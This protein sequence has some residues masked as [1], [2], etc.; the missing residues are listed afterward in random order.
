M[1]HFNYQSILRSIHLSKTPILIGGCPR[2]GTSLLLSILGAHS[3]IFAYPDETQIFWKKW[4][5]KSLQYHRI[6]HLNAFYQRLIQEDIPYGKTHWCEK[7]PLN[8]HAFP[9]LLKEFKGKIKLIHIIRDGRD[10]VLSHHPGFRLP[11]FVSPERWIHDMTL[12]LQLE[13]H[14]SYYALRYEDL[15]LDF[16]S[17]MRSLLDFLGFEWEDRLYL[18]HKHTNV[19]HI[20]AWGEQGVRP[21]DESSIYRWKQSA[22][23]QRLDEFYYHP[24][25]HLLLKHLGYELPQ[26]QLSLITA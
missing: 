10:V 9:H 2:S 22:D 24:H 12:G 8:L 1:T 18:F 15:I 6:R 5:D 21:L 19:K 7:S 11:Y 3:K 4:E 25:S 13:H 20:H 23:K 16:E 17:T 26:Q 14:P